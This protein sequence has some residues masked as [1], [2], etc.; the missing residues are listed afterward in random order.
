MSVFTC[1]SCWRG[2]HDCEGYV[3]NAESAGKCDCPA[4]HPAPTTE[5]GRD[6]G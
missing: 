4:C 2:T 6:D 3:F 5:G 1:R